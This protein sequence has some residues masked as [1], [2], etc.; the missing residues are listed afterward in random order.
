MQM[1]KDEARPEAIRRWHL[2]PP[3]QRE[4][5]SDAEAYAAR[6]ELELDFQTVTNKRK[7]ITAWL[8]LEL[9][10]E[11]LAADDAARQER[12]ARA[13]QQARAEQA[14]AAQHAK[15]A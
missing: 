14:K 3:H 2:L 13:E 10:R 4:T 8:I 5:Y 7:L 12:K 1:S 11:F 15:A 9:D 6:L